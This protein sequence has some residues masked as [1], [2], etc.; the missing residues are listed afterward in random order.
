MKIQKLLEKFKNIIKNKKLNHLY[1]F[2]SNILND[3]EQLDFIF[4]LSYEFLKTEDFSTNLKHLIKNFSYPNFYYLNSEDNSIIKKEKIREMTQYFHYTSLI[5]NKKV[6]VINK[7]EKLSYEA[8][9][10]LLYFLENPINNNILGILITK[11]YNLVL[12]TIISR[13]QFFNLDFFIKDNSKENHFS[14]E[15]LDFSLN[16]NNK[17][18]HILISLLNKSRIK[19]IQQKIKPIYYNNFKKFFLTFIKNF[20]KDFSFT[21]LFLDAINLLEDNNFFHDFLFII[22]RFFLDLYYSKIKMDTF[23]NEEIFNNFFF[24]KISLEVVNIFLK[25]FIKIEKQSYF[26]DYQTIFLSLLIQIDKKHKFFLLYYK[27]EN[28]NF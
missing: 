8:S 7:I 24:K 27:K 16:K 17:L 3:A 22:T 5:Q 14:K 11:N 19:K 28:N 20:E 6:Y 26:L 23:F 15:F 25:I 21:N 12:P 4:N 13:T 9:N 1:L 2:E 10:S 18:D